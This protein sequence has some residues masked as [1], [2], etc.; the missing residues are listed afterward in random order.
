[1]PRDTSYCLHHCH[2]SM[3]K[4]GLGRSML[5]SP[6]WLTFLLVISKGV[7]G[8]LCM[9][10]CVKDYLYKRQSAERQKGWE[11]GKE[12]EWEREREREIFQSSIHCSFLNVHSSW[13][14]AKRKL[15][16]QNSILVSYMSGRE[17][18]V[19]SPHINR[20]LDWKQCGWD[21]NQALCYR[22]SW[23][24]CYA[25]MPTWNIV[26]LKKNIIRNNVVL[27]L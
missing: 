3:I 11:R 20:E 8:I 12:W 23:L 7:Q 25:T 22:M 1:M 4:A 27:S 13:D 6:A 9:R 15:G 2:M 17:S 19:P 5:C 26:F 14:W 10:M 21:S 16:A 18:D 24:N